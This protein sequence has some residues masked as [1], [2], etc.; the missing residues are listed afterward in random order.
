M[1][2]LKISH[3]CLLINQE[4]R[5]REGRQ[6]E[7]V[8]KRRAHS[9]YKIE[10]EAV[11]SRLSLSKTAYAKFKLDILHEIKC[12]WQAPRKQQ[13]VEIRGESDSDG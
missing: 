12:E 2:A 9:N 11:F 8:H 13:P 5:E 4:Q 1:G 6:I 7:K 10:H 3:E